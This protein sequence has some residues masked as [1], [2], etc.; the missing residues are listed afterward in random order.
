VGLGGGVLVFLF[1]FRWCFFSLPLR[2]LLY[3]WG[4]SFADGFS[5]VVLCL[6]KIASGQC[7]QSQ[8]LGAF[9]FFRAFFLLQT[10]FR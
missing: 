7:R 8:I 2:V 6:F 1:F 5:R 10:P 3:L 9:P 4:L